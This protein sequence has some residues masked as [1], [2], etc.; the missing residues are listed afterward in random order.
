V[1]RARRGSGG[2]ALSLLLP[3][4]FCGATFA[5]ANEPDPP[6]DLSAHL[7]ARTALR[8]V[9][10]LEVLGP[11]AVG[12]EASWKVVPHFGLDGTVSYEDMQYGH[13][14]VGVEAL[15]RYF[16]FLGPN[17]LSVGL[18]PAFLAANE[19]GAVAF[20][21]SELSYEYRR[22]G[23]LSVLI[24]VGAEIALNNSGTATCPQQGWFSCF[25]WVDH[26]SAGDFSYHLRLALGTAF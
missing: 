20:A 17:A 25:L 3:F 14:G 16:P 4:F 8:A 6:P 21:R 7:A 18:G 23:T 2:L 26:Y 5:R 1:W 19:Y 12:L 24:G 15:A 13:Q 9:G 22:V 11:A 10:S